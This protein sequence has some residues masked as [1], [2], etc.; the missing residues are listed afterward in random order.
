MAVLLALWLWFAASLGN[1]ACLEQPTILIVRDAGPTAFGTYTPATRTVRVE[2]GLNP[3]MMR[4]VAVHEY[5][6]HWYHTCR[7]PDRPVGRRFLTRTG[8]TWNVEGKEAFAHTL[9]WTLT[10][11]GLSSGRVQ[12][13]AVCLFAPKIHNPTPDMSLRMEGCP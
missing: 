10:G 8:L 11:Q 9:T 13:R 12:R 5:A 2:A 4:L 6:H 1:P 7:I 3:R